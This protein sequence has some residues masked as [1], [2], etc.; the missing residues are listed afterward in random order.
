MICLP[1]FAVS[2]LRM[3]SDGEGVT[4][5][6]GVHGCPLACRMCINA[7]SVRRDAAVVM[8]SVESLIDVLKIDSIYFAATGG[9]VTF[10]GG[11]PLVHPEFLARFAQRKPKEWRMNV[12]TSL[13]VPESAV[14]ALLDCV[15]EWIVDVKELNPEIYRAYTGRENDSVLHN[16]GLLRGARGSVRLRVPLIPGFNA[17]EDCASSE[18]ILRQMGFEKIER[19][20]YRTV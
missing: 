17:P 9:G 6:V 15:D 20:S 8:Q 4:S 12:E 2:R 14:A 3:G 18:Q 13:N 19:F 1:V 11:E 16:L 5:L 7:R 10:G